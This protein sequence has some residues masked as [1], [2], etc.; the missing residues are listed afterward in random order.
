[1][2]PSLQFGMRFMCETKIAGGAWLTVPRDKLDPIPL[3]ERR[4]PR[5]SLEMNVLSWRDITG[6]TPDATSGMTFEHA[7]PGSGPGGAEPDKAAAADIAAAVREHDDRA[8]LLSPED[9]S[10]LEEGEGALSEA[11]AAPVNDVARS[12]VGIQPGRKGASVDKN[13]ASVSEGLAVAPLK[14]LAV[15]V[16]TAGRGSVDAHGRVGPDQP[17]ASSQSSK[18]GLKAKGKA[19][20]SS[21]ESLKSAAPA[22]TSSAAT[23][24]EMLEGV[25]GSDVAGGGVALPNRDP[26]LMISNR[27]RRSAEPDAEQKLVVFTFREG[28]VAPPGVEG[29]VF[30]TESEMLRAWKRF[31]SEEADPDVICLFQL[32][33]SLR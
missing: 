9:E 22:I 20:V 31:V 17:A 30:K 19:A 23:E 33:E 32:K 5:C 11:G 14:I 13:I 12:K 4:A 15:N 10:L 29:R 8:S 28:F 1:M 27:I 2:F 3:P 25:P 6:L 18:R 26:V 21:P 7:L 16:Q 24:L